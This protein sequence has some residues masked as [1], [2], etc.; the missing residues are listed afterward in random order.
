[1]NPF[2]IIYNGKPVGVQPVGDGKYNLST[3]QNLPDSIYYHTKIADSGIAGWSFA[4]FKEKDD[5]HPEVAAE[6]GEEI[7]R[8]EGTIQSR[9]EQ[10]RDV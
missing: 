8:I 10:K 6:I 1:M 5:N 3:D 2:T 9:G 4:R 7:R